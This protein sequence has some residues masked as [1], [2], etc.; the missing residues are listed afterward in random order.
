MGRLFDAVASL[1]DVRHEVDYEAQAAIELEALAGQAD[2][3]WSAW[4]AA[5]LTQADPGGPLVIDPT[6]WIARALADHASGVPVTESALAFHL[7]VADA[8]T[9]ACV[10]I[11]AERGVGTVGLTGGV[12]AN[13]ILMQACVEQLGSAGFTVLTHRVVPANDGGLALGQVAVAAAG[14]AVAAG[15]AAPAR[16][17]R[18]PTAR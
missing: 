13:A 10:A 9:Q 3:D 15:T 8:L 18:T 4:P 6:P 7:A 14:G 16:P 12:F 5:T 11:R 2:A 17:A 1:L